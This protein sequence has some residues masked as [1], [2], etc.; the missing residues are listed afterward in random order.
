MTVFGSRAPPKV[1]VYRSTG[2]I[3][4]KGDC[5]RD[6]LSLLIRSSSFDPFF[7]IDFASSIQSRAC[8][9]SAIAFPSSLFSRKSWTHS[10]TSLLA[11]SRATCDVGVIS[12]F[13]FIR[14]SFLSRHLIRQA[15]PMATT[16]RSIV[17][18]LAPSDF[19]ELSVACAANPR[20]FNRGCARIIP[21]SPLGCRITRRRREGCLASRGGNLGCCGAGSSPLRREGCLTCRS[22]RLRRFVL[23]A[24]GEK[25]GCQQATES[26]LQSVISHL[27]APCFHFVIPFERLEFV[28]TAV[29]P[30]GYPRPAEPGAARVSA[31]VKASQSACVKLRACATASRFA[32]ATLN[33]D[34]P[35]AICSAISTHACALLSDGAVI[36]SFRARTS[37]SCFDISFMYFSFS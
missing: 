28:A 25:N 9:S 31:A 23:L 6:Q 22:S 13:W 10:S 2:E 7:S 36:E 19:I 21:S 29:G 35:A 20:V 1:T 16:S 27:V 33:S 18:H 26:G 14:L 15:S 4:P 8:S 11:V 34:K 37:A 24:A 30:G 5:C 12:F 3:A 17:A 32:D